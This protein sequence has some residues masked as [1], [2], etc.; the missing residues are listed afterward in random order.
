VRILAQFGKEDIAIV[1]L[2]ET[3]KGNLVEFVEALQPPFPREEKWVLI[4]S[5]LNGCPV[6]CKMCDAGGSYAGVLDKDEI[7]EQIDFMVKKRYPAGKVNTKKFKVQFA[8][9]G[10]PAFNH[11]V[12]EVLE[13]LSFYDNLIPSISTVAPVGCDQFFEELL[14]IKDRFYKGRFQLQFSI[15]STDEKQ[16]DEIIPVKKWS[17]QQVAEYGERFVS[18]GDRKVTLN[19]A[20]FE[21]ANVEAVRLIELFSPQKFLIK[22]TP[23]N[24]T[25]SS[26]NNGIVSDVDLQ[27]GLPIKNRKFVEE[28]RENGFEVILSVG[29]PEENKIGSNCGLYIRRHLVES[30]K[31]RDAYTYIPR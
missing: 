7:L 16:R 18:E 19:F 30:S 11:H 21:Q 2:G 8:R 1:Y 13:E 9:V 5:T 15:H 6:K 24:P 20:L 14:R 17:L 26:I 22:V 27:S 10:E 29:E 25:Y 31:P 3:S 12:L 23:V 4:V 28:L